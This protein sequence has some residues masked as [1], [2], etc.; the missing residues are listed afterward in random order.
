MV[1][2]CYSCTKRFKSNLELCP[3]CQFQNLKAISW[4]PEELKIQHAEN[5]KSV[6]VPPTI[7][8][9]K[10]YAYD[11]AKDCNFQIT[12][13]TI[14][15][16]FEGVIEV[17]Q[18]NDDFH[19]FTIRFNPNRLTRH[20][21]NEIRAMLR[22]EIMHPI[23]MQE[24]SKII[25][26]DG[27]PEIQE[28]QAAVQTAYD[29]MINYKEYS[30]RFPNDP[31]LHSAKQKIYT[32]FSLI[33]L[34]V[35]SMLKNNNIQ[36][37]HPLLFVQALAVYEDAV[38]N[39]FE[40]TTKLE[41]WVSENSAQALYEFLRWI[42]EDFN[43]IQNNV[44]NRDEMREIIFLTFKMMASVSI[45]LIYTSNTLEFNA[46]WSVAYQHCQTHYPDSLGIQLLS[47]WKKRFDESPKIFSSN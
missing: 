10:Q 36:Q 32:N 11:A 41:H 16:D 42:H 37:D 6:I 23:T 26:T 29:E 39:F 12:E 1:V 14:T 5:H 24:S 9:I 20:N 17:L 18:S 13:L 34:G 3:H 31:D 7:S 28:L 44:S 21:V 38:Y 19:K 47:L 46:M 27:P 30:K 8:E 33:F 45:D 2:R 15:D 43:I 22:H 25:V 40:D 35:K 4:L